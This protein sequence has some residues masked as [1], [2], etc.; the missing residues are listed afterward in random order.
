MAFLQLEA[1]IL[2]LASFCTA[3]ACVADEA[4][5]TALIAAA[6]FFC[7]VR[8]CFCCCLPAAVWFYCDFNKLHSC[9]C[10]GLLRLF[11]VLFPLGSRLSLCSCQQLLLF[12][13]A[14]ALF[15]FFFFFFFFR[16]SAQLSPFSSFKAAS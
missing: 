12:S 15:F 6:S 4:T 2:Q 5:S 13:A 3:A 11:S 16:F 7:R 1:E 10:S 14:V 9:C 8:F